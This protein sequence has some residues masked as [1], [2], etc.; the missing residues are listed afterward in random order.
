MFQ[1]VT[2]KGTRW[3]IFWPEVDDVDGANEAIR[4]GYIAC[5]VLAIASAIAAAFGSIE[6]VAG[7]LVFGV[8]GLLLRRKSRTASLIAA[9]LM[10]LNII[11]TLMS[12]VPIVG[13][14]AMIIFACLLSGVRETFA[15]RRLIAGSA[16]DLI[17]RAR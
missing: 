7:F 9:A 6:N 1:E 8:L 10:A 5:F 3:R 17:Q 2:R 12:G 13:V 11:A 14:V 16:D 15:Y 4:L